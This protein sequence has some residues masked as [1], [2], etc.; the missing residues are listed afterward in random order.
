MEINLYNSLIL[1]EVD[2]LAKELLLYC[3]CPATCVINPPSRI[4]LAHLISKVD[5]V[6]TQVICAKYKGK[7]NTF[8]GLLPS[9]V[10]I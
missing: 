2:K 3:K 4:Q 7:W 9:E 10:R 8:A 6:I 1:M 5:Q